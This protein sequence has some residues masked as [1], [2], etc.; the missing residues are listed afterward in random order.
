M[1]LALQEQLAASHR[2]APR[3]IVTIRYTDAAGSNVIDWSDG[4]SSATIID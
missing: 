4:T 3:Q 1:T 2:R